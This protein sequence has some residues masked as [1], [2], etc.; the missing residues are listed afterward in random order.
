MAVRWMAGVM[1]VS[2]GIG[3]AREW[4]GCAGGFAE[5]VEGEEK[6]GV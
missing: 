4:G 2:P 5:V 1:E 6:I 3:I